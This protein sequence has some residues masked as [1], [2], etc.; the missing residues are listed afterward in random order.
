MHNAL[1][2]DEIA[3]RIAKQLFDS[4]DTLDTNPPCDEAKDDLEP[5]ELHTLKSIITIFK[6]RFTFL[7]SSFDGTVLPQCPADIPWHWGGTEWLGSDNLYS[8]RYPRVL[9]SDILLVMPCDAARSGFFLSGGGVSAVAT[10]MPNFIEF[11][12]SDPPCTSTL[13]GV[14]VGSLAVLVAGCTRLKGL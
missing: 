10:T 9:S 4:N 14:S 2:V 8:N 13:V 12:L 3:R 6:K 5:I 7:Q 11:Y 1:L